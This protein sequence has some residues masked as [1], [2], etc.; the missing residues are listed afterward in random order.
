MARVVERHVSIVAVGNWNPS[1]FHP[2]W[3]RRNKAIGK[4]ESTEALEKGVVVTPDLCQW[5]FGSM[6]VQVFRNRFSVRCTEDPLVRAKDFAG[7]CFQKLSHTPVTAMG[8][9]NTLI[10]ETESEAHWRKFGDKLA[11]QSNWSDLFGAPKARNGG[12][13]SMLMVSND[14]PDK[15]PGFIQVKVDSVPSLRISFEVN[16]HFQVVGEDGSSSAGDL[17]EMLES[18]WVKC[19]RRSSKI[20]EGL[21]HLDE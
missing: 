14:R 10:V 16:D 13:V 8:I 15:R 19:S 6:H 1:I 18:E 9:N 2:E 5:S 3:V 7:V 4:D 20:V 21:R 17:Q 11:P 12:L